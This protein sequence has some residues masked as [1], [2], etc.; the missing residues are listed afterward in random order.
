MHTYVIILFVFTASI[1]EKYQL[2]V[3]NLSKLMAFIN[4]NFLQIKELADGRTLWIETNHR[5]L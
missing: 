3:R 2:L 5:G 4:H 1:I